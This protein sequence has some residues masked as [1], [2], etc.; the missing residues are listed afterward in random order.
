MVS[1]QVVCAPLDHQKHVARLVHRPDMH[2]LA[3]SVRLL[4]EP[5]GCCV[6]V[7]AQN[8]TGQTSQVPHRR[9]HDLTDLQLGR[10]SLNFRQR[11]RIQRSDNAVGQETF[12]TQQFNN[13]L[14]ETRIRPVVLQL[15]VQL[16]SSA[17]KTDD[18][19]QRRK[20][21]GS[22]WMLPPTTSQKRD[23]RPAA[24]SPASSV[25]PPSRIRNRAS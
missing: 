4:N 25:N 5:S 14:R 2:L 20:N 12:P 9:R 19:G 15:D 13:L 11:D 6:L 8:L 18:L 10:Q 23:R 17:G 16:D 24:T 7:H 21:A 3:R 1:D 22:R